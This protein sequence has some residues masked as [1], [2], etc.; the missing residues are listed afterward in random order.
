M[1]KST[2]RGVSGQSNSRKEKDEKLLTAKADFKAQIEK[3]SRSLVA[4]DFESAL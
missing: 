4:A 1:I 2:L 3:F